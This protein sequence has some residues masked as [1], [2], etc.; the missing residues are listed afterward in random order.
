M[1]QVR[2]A[3]GRRKL[4][5]RHGGRGENSEEDEKGVSITEAAKGFRYHWP[6][7]VELGMEEVAGE[8]GGGMH[9]RCD[10]G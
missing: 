3:S 7:R 6:K 4:P 8:P 10:E 1:A 9:A 2:G 5:E